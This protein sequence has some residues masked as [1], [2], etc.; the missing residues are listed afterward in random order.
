MK[1]LRNN[2]GFSL[3]EMM[4]VLA[5]LV[6]LV[7][8]MGS[9]MD[10]GSMIYREAIFEA[11]SGSL[12][13]ILN[14]ALGDILR[15]SYTGEMENLR[16][17]I[18]GEPDA[19]GNVEFFTTS[20]GTYLAPE[21][22]GFVFTNLEYGVVDAYFH[23]PMSSDGTIKGVLQIRNLRNSNVIELVNTGAYPD[24]VISD[25]RITYTPAG[26]DGLRGGYF[27]IS[28]TIFSEKHEGLKR[29]VETVVRLMNE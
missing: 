24:L 22:V 3:V 8:G 6:V 20:D 21:Q 19:A 13:G 25:F 4:A 16:I 1:K 28:Y 29:D 11:D 7:M 2:K 9:T 27:Y 23:T 17:K 15:H 12:S 14:T 26:E 18:N 10:A 5:I